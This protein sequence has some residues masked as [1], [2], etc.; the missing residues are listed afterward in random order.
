MCIYN[1]KYR[2]QP[3]AQNLVCSGWPMI[4]PSVLHMGGSWSFCKVTCSEAFILSA[5]KL[6]FLKAPL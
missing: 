2:T 1:I 4:G 3:C 6:L 5:V